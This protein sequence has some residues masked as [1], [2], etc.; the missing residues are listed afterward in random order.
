M[1][2][3]VL[4]LLVPAAI[5]AA[6]AFAPVSASGDL[7]CQKGRP[8]TKAYCAKKCVVPKLRGKTVKQAKFALRKH[9]CQLGK[10]VR[11]KGKGVRKGRILKSSPKAHTQH[12]QG[13]KVRVFVRKK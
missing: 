10:V 12:K 3:K 8:H 9:D 4:L 2:R 11:I 1:I 5:V 6:V 13:A 7:I